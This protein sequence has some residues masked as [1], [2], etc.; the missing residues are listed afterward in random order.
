MVKI[1]NKFDQFSTAVYCR[2]WNLLYDYSNVLLFVLGIMIIT[3]GVFNLDAVAELDN[4]G[5]NSKAGEIIKEQLCKILGLLQGAFGAL[6]L[7]VAGLAA[8]VTAAMGAYKLAMSCVVIA[9]GAWVI[10]AFMMLFFPNISCDE[11]AKAGKVNK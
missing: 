10:E 4:T 7:V 2:S 6:I 9:C 5:G 1:V 3:L 8:V 11:N